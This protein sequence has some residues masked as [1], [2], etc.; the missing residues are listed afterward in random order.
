[1]IGRHREVGGVPSEIVVKRTL[2]TKA[3]EAPSGEF[4]TQP[5]SAMLVVGLRHKSPQILTKCVWPA[6]ARSSMGLGLVRQPGD[7]LWPG[8]RERSSDPSPPAARA[9]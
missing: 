1:M 8:S 5:K 4:S 7:K 2:G 6:S 9:V 3:D